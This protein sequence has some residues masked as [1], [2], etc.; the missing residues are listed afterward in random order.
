M[1][2]ERAVR[3]TIR[4]FVIPR[5]RMLAGLRASTRATTP[6]REWTNMTVH[7]LGTTK[8]VVGHL[9][10]RGPSGGTTRSLVSVHWGAGP[11]GP[12]VLVE[13]RMPGG[14]AAEAQFWNETFL[15]SGA[16]NPQPNAWLVE[17]AS[18][19]KPGR[20]LDVA[21]GQGRNAIWLARQGWDVTGYDIAADG[22]RIARETAAAGNLK[23][24]TVLSSTEKFDFGSERWDLVA[25]IYGGGTGDEIARAAKGLKRGGHL[26]LEGFLGNPGTA[27]SPGSG[28]TFNRQFLLD[29]CPEAGL[30]V[31]RY[32]EPEA[33]PITRRT[34]A[35]CWQET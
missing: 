27:G 32:E 23:L 29:K 28:V 30:E 16:F 3:I 6:Q 13:Q 14:E 19:L 26:V 34:A 8:L 24:D 4:A 12:C 17:V 25:I 31:V 22:L 33:Q 5:D 20:A 7:D 21:M 35:R 2:C 18:K 11:K 10:L 15:V 1:L 9:T